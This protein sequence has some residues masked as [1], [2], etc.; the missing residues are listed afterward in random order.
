MPYDFNSS[1]FNTAKPAFVSTFNKIDHIA[2]HPKTVPYNFN[3]DFSKIPFLTSC[4]N[5]T[6]SSSTCH[7]S[8][9]KQKGIIFSHLNI[10][11]IVPKSLSLYA[12]LQQHHIDIMSVNE[13]WLHESHTNAS[14]FLPG[15]DIHR[16]DR[17]SHGGGVA[18]LV[19][20]KLN[21]AIENSIL[22]HSIELLHIVIELPFSKPVNVITIYHPPSSNLQ[23]MFDTLCTFL[24]N[25]DYSHLP[26]LILGDFNIDMLA[27]NNNSS[28]SQFNALLKDYG[29]NVYGNTPTRITLSTSTQIDLLI[30]NSLAKPFING[31][32]TITTGISDHELL[33]FGYKKHEITKPP[34]KLITHTCMSQCSLNNILTSIHSIPIIEVCEGNDA[35]E[36]LNLYMHKLS[37]ILKTIPS[38]QRRISGL[39]HPWI[40][41]EFIKLTKKRDN[42]F[43]LAKKSKN[44]HILHKAKSTRNKC[45]S[46]SRELKKMYISNSL[47]EYKNNPKRLWQT[48]RPFYSNKIIATPQYK[49]N[50]SG[51]LYTDQLEVANYFNTHFIN[52][53]TDLQS[54]FVSNP[55]TTSC[56]IPDIYI[57]DLNTFKFNQTTIEIIKKILKQIKKGGKSSSSIHPKIVAHCIEPLAIQLCAIINKCIL[58]STFPDIWKSADII[59]VYKSGSHTDVANYRPISLLPNLSK[60]FERVMHHQI[61]C[62]IQEHALFPTCQHGFR[63]NHSTTTCATALT[64]YIN[65]NLDAGNTVV[66]LF[67]DF[68]KAFDLISHDILL[69]KLKCLRFS[70]KSLQLIKSYLSARK[71]RVICDDKFSDFLNALFGFP[72]GSI[73]G[74]LLFVLYIY[75][76]SSCIHHSTIFQFADDTTLGI[77]KNNLAHI[78]SLLQEDIKSFEAYCQTN[79]LLINAEKTKAMIFLPKNRRKTVDISQLSINIHGSNIGFVDKFKFLG[80]HLDSKLSFKLHINHVISK[81]TSASF[82]LLKCR[83]FLPLHIRVLLFNAIGLAHI[84]YASVVYLNGI[85]T[86]LFRKLESRYVDCGRIM[87]FNRKGSSRSLTLWNL[88]W[89][90]LREHLTKTMLNYLYAIITTKAPLSL[91]NYLQMPNHSHSTRHSRNNFAL[92][93]IK[94]NYGRKAFSYW[95]PYMWSILP[96]EIKN[97]SN[98]NA[99]DLAIFCNINT[100]SSTYYER[101]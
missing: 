16:L 31:F 46:M 70:N 83:Q 48:L 40:T 71:Q 49:L 78:F 98:P 77:A 5:V 23:N 50:M 42:L 15:Y 32:Q 80:I 85:N 90:P 43:S 24:N 41:P 86:S 68:S 33:T 29:L 95:A 96:N 4:S 1:Y 13:T 17:Q 76:M 89:L 58:L 56:I 62:H 79:R 74:P 54:K 100:L 7:T 3:N 10:C 82:I 87:L 2:Y 92:P 99:F 11:S 37:E 59:P 73:L 22:T 72:Q 81:L 57:S 88:K 67:L 18:V 66:C 61:M 63:S 19:S 34:H 44:I 28:K 94:S 21:S 27:N 9:N 20:H 45:T 38:R 36:I 51:I 53:I 8:Y 69:S 101:F 12:I 64:T 65:E 6:T 39:Q 30:C 93:S 26:L 97:S 84:N 91:F 75:D 14:L 52:S 35:N 55:S 25:L 47:S 60:V